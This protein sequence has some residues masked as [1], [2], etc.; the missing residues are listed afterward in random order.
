MKP[1]AA[2]PSPSNNELP[3]TIQI[4]DRG[5]NR[6]CYQILISLRLRPK[7]RHSFSQLR[8]GARSRRQ[9]EQSTAS[10]LKRL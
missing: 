10:N 5:A 4:L 1:F 6:F 2:A 9:P 7:S 3:A 8:G